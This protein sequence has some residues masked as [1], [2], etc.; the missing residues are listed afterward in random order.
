MIR[1]NLLPLKEVRHAAERRNELRLAYAVLAAAA[2]AVVLAFVGLNR[3]AAWR[4]G[5]LVAVKAEIEEVRKVV[6]EVEAEEQKRAVLQ[7]KR[8][9]IADLERKEV[10]PLKIL[11]A[12]S[13]ATP[14]RLWLTEFV[15]SGGTVTITGLAID[16]PT[17]ADFLAKL[18][19]S[20]HFNGL[21]LLESAQ[22]DQTQ[23]R[24]KKFVMKGPLN[25]F[26]ETARAVAQQ[27]PQQ[28]GTR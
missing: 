9:I 1:I 18:Q 25:Y 24:V 27:Q 8:R 17:V 11:E 26:G 3:L 10:G 28:G 13:E 20:P 6:H 14:I 5:Q 16:D 15:D 22:A 4:Q 12:V 23:N 21:E 7:E 19:R 2:A